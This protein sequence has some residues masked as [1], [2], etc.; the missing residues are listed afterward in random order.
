MNESAGHYYDLQ[1]NAVFEVPNKTK[2]GMRP[3]TI[4]DCRK[5]G[6]I[7]SVTTF[8][9]CLS[10]PEL[11]RW[12]QTQVLL[13][14]MTLPRIQDESDEE[15]MARVMVDAFAQV[16]D[17]ADLGTRV[18]AALENH[19]QGRPY[20]TSLKS[21]IDPVEAWVQDNGITFVEHEIRLVSPEWGYA[22]TTDALI[23]AIGREGVGVLDFKTRKSKPQYP[24]KPWSTEPIQIAAY[25]RIKE[26][27]FGVNLFISTTEPGRVESTWYE[28]D[29]MDRDF[30][31][32]T[33]IIQLWSYLNNYDARQLTLA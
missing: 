22:G 14:S 32:F 5:M 15:W 18:H 33:H 6:L 12:K 1:G 20:D 16:D 10:K 9:K 2:G 13:A 27:S 30:D 31:A 3:T 21:Y 19:F 24:M 23:T 28:K 7:P 8:F 29:Q 11:D 17:A 26:A 25:G 4:S